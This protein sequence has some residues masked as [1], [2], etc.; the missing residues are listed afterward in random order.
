M[1]LVEVDAPFLELDGSDRGQI[2]W[3]GTLVEKG[4]ASVSLE[5]SESHRADG[6]V[7]GELLVVYSDSVSVS[8]GVRE[9]S[10]LQDGVCRGLNTGNH[11]R[12][13]CV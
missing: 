10:G 12:W 8:V 3:S 1:N 9:E 7:D 11:V 5:V 2:V 6:R 13:V 4:H